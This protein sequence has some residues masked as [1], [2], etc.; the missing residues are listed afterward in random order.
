LRQIKPLLATLLSVSELFISFFQIKF[1]VVLGVVFTLVPCSTMEEH[2]S[3][4]IMASGGGR[5]NRNS[6]RLRHPANGTGGSG[7]GSGG[8]TGFSNRLPSPIR[9]NNMENR[10]NPII[11]VLDDSDDQDDE[12][13]PAA[14]A[15]AAAAAVISPA[16]TTE[17]T[18][19]TAGVRRTTITSGVAAAT[20]GSSSSSS[21]RK[22]RHKVADQTSEFPSVWWT[23]Q[24]PD[25]SAPAGS[26]TTSNKKEKSSSSSTNSKSCLFDGSRSQSNNNNTADVVPSSSSSLS[27]SD[28]ACQLWSSPL[29]AKYASAHHRPAGVFRRLGI[30]N[31]DLIWNSSKD[32][33]ISNKRKGNKSTNKNLSLEQRLR[34]LLADKH[35]N[36]SKSFVAQAMKIPPSAV[37]PP[38]KHQVKKDAINF[39]NQKSSPNPRKMTKL[40]KKLDDFVES[41]MKDWNDVVNMGPIKPTWHP[42]TGQPCCDNGEGLVSTTNI[43]SSAPSAGVAAAAA[44][45][46]SS[47][48]F[49]SGA[50]GSSSSSSSSSIDSTSIMKLLRLVQSGTLRD[51]GP[52]ASKQKSLYGGLRVIDTDAESVLK[53]LVD[54]ATP[55]K[56]LYQMPLLLSVPKIQNIELMSSTMMVVDDDDD[57]T[58]FVKVRISIGC[59]AH[60]LLFEV[61]TQGLQV[62]LAAMSDDTF[63]VTQNMSSPPCI[64]RDGSNSNSTNTIDAAI[65]AEGRVEPVFASDP[66]GPQV[67]F[68]HNDDEED[69]DD[70]DNAT[71][72]SARTGTGGKSKA[73]GGES[74]EDEDGVKEFDDTAAFN[75][76]L[77]VYSPQGFLKWIENH[78]VCMRNWNHVETLLKNKLDID[79]ML[80]QKHGVT[81]MYEQEKLSNGI[82]SLIWEQRA[83]PEGDKYW[84]SPAL[85]QLRL[86]LNNTTTSTTTAA[87]KAAT[88][89]NATTAVRGG[90]LADEM[91]L[92]KTAQVVALIV[93][94]LPEI[95]EDMSVRDGESA[96]SASSP[97]TLIV[98]P[99]ALINQWV[100][101][102][103]KVSSKLVVHFFDHKTD[104]FVRRTDHPSTDQDADVVLT[105]YQALAT[106]SFQIL[107]STVWARVVLD[108]MQVRI[109]CLGGL[110]PVHSFHHNVLFLFFVSFLQEIRSNT[111]SIAKN[112]NALMA[113]RR[114]ML[115]GTP[116]FEG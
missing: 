63:E 91:G 76:K 9:N 50:N 6:P 115:S 19:T 31:L 40:N 52:P 28:R 77:D 62:V 2:T 105:T 39:F 73:N 83:F 35:N 86:N 104:Q 97:A 80:H 29:G 113:D 30:I 49:T 61:M 72:T 81:F 98:V 70:Q 36:N 112:C 66:D 15:A 116:L 20:V 45:A 4:V 18:T 16:T 23:Y 59:Y 69:G 71:N 84:Y 25:A 107:G 79:L 103:K 27:L 34:R 56:D 74:E 11:V 24:L 65:S 93:A 37:K 44:A 53:S 22:K 48:A 82:N 55:S 114:W 10:K 85:G 51:A 57:D 102:I 92:G 47:S 99:P 106:S 78:G 3:S 87:A 68:D 110:S 95:K 1:F 90:I 33:S 100:D 12:A 14:A 64:P 43:A 88:T 26:S 13:K 21:P 75:G 32:N 46:K 89:K 17:S 38:T 108:E 7:G 96:S 109:S 54:L 41:L 5:G 60:R 8:G 67:V 111:T 42:K 101:E 94:T 58:A